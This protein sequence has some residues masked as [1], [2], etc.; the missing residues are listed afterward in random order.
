[1]EQWNKEYISS[2]TQSDMKKDMIAAWRD[3]DYEEEE[4]SQPCEETTNIC[5]M[6][7]D[8]MEY[9]DSWLLMPR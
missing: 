9:D 5:L 1:M 6:A 8:D 7:I 3:N 4:D 2:Y